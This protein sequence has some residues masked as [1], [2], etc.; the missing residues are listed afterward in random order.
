MGVN[1]L[2]AGLSMLT[3]S[4][5]CAILSA[6]ISIYVAPRFPLKWLVFFGYGLTALG[7]GERNAPDQGNTG[8]L[9]GPAPLGTMMALNQHSPIALQEC[10]PLIVGLGFSFLL[11]LPNDLLTAAL[12]DKHLASANGNFFLVRTM[13]C[14]TGLSI[15]SAIFSTR[16]QALLQPVSYYLDPETVNWK[17]LV[18]I[19][20]V[21]L[22]EQV[23][24][25]VSR[26]LGVCAHFAHLCCFCV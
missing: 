19:E 11:K 26:A 14:T 23:L 22:K 17:A 20:P 21:E 6:P 18:H 16:L 12:R 1:A 25:A 7:F 5:T 24:G 2:K 4:L 15:A 3:F 8:Y 10:L 9:L 13:G